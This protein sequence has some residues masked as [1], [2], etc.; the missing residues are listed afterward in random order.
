MKLD[1]YM[2]MALMFGAMA[3]SANQPMGLPRGDKRRKDYED[4]AVKPKKKIIPKGCK[5]YHFFNPEFSCIASS[6]KSAN[7][8]YEKFKQSQQ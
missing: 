2:A 8:K 7:K 5:E 1:K 4:E 6:E 3:A